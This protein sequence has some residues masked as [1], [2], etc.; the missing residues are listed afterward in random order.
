MRFY[1]STPGLIAITLLSVFF[2]AMAKPLGGPSGPAAALISS[3]YNLGDHALSSAKLG[4]NLT[5]SVKKLDGDVVSSARN[6]PDACYDTA[7][8]NDGAVKQTFRGTRDVGDAALDSAN[9]LIDNIISSPDQSYPE[10]IDLA[11]LCHAESSVSSIESSFVPYYN[12]DAT[13]DVN[14]F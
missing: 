12:G 4:E 11:I 7:G 2:S 9:G 8:Y 1:N 14:A 10:N 6:F 3:A 13:A 5:S